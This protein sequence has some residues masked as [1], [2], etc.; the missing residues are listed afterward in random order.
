MQDANKPN[1]DPQAGVD[2]FAKNELVLNKDGFYVFHSIVDG[3]T[4]A[5]YDVIFTAF[6]PCQVIAAIETHRVK[7]TDAGAVTL[8]LEK[9]TSGQALN[10]GVTLLQ[11]AWDLKSTINTPVI[12]QGY[13]LANGLTLVSLDR[14]LETGDRLALKDT[15]TLTA[16]AGVCVTIYL[17]FWGK[18]QY[19]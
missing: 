11:T 4:A 19:R 18:G 6:R 16:V 8:N 13:Q 15:G 2:Q 10:S 17:K 3:A 14:N 7:G 5:N 9:L 1:M 12:K